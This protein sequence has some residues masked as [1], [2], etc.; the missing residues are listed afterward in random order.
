MSIRSTLGSIA[1]YHVLA[2]AFLFGATVYQSFFAGIIAFKTLPY[3]QFSLLQSKVF[4]IYFSMQ[5][6]LSTFLLLTRPV[7]FEGTRRTVNAVLAT[8]FLCTFINLLI[9]APLT[10]RIMEGRRRQEEVDGRSCRDAVQSPEMA[11]L[12]KRFKKIHGFSVLV[13]L[14]ALLSL[15]F[16]SVLLTDGLL[17]A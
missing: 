10:R 2:Y 8:V 15:I 17:K 11:A 12:N 1:P 3:Q 6:I 7:A 14:A 13:N 16:Y 9:L 5:A 4:P